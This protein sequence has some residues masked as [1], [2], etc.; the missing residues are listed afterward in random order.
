[1][2]IAGRISDRDVK[3]TAACR[4]FLQEK[5]PVSIEEVPAVR[6]L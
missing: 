5:R 2:T 1:M 6:P 3:L 4:S